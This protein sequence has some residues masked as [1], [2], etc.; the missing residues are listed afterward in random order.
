MKLVKKQ[1]DP[2]TGR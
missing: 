1:I 2:D